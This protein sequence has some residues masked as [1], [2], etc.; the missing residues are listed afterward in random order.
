MLLIGVGFGLLP[1]WRASR[2]D[3][4]SALG[5]IG[6]GSTLDGGTRRLLGGLI[7]VEIAI[8]AVLLMGS[9]TLTQY[10]RKVVHEPWGFATEHRLVFNAMLSDRLFDSQ[11]TRERTIDAT[12]GELR[13]LPGVRSASVTAP[14]PMEAARD[15][16]G[17]VP[18]AASRRN[19]AVPT[20][21]ICAERRRDI[22]RQ[23]VN[24][25]CAGAT[26]PKPIAP[27]RRRSAS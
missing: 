5:S 18:R 9:L 10:F 1:A 20:L 21:R 16:M 2:T 8:A 7:I 4:R 26:L 14:S 13:S 25:W 11:E 23:L 15:L 24:A 6:R 19:R 27:I 17:C 22:S 3:L 12:L